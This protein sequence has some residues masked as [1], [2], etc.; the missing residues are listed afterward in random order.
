M[1]AAP[2]LTEPAGTTPDL[3]RMR[4][5]AAPRRRS[6]ARGARGTRRGRRAGDPAGALSERRK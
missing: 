4:G 5:G 1:V 3:R 2:T 6:G